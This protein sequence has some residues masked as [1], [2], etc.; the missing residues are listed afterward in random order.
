MAMTAQNP[1]YV[2]PVSNGFNPFKAITTFFS[3][4]GKSV[5]AS[6]DFKSLSTLS[7]EE[8]AKKGLKRENVPTYILTL[9]F[10]DS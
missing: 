9:Y 4:F 2:A 5:A 7:N 3:L 8:L 6:N 10:G 1:T